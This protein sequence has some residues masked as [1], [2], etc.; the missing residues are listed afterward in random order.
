MTTS[1]AA[2]L[3]DGLVLHFD[4][5]GGPVRLPDDVLHGL[6]DLTVTAQVGHLPGGRRTITCTLG[7]GTAIHYEDGVET[8]RKTSAATTPDAIDD[9]IATCAGRAADGSLQS[10]VRDFRLYR[11]VLAPGEVRE[12]GKETASARPGADLASLDLG[13]ASAVTEDLTLSTRAPG[14]SVI[15]WES[16]RPS[17]LS[18]TGVVTRPAPRAGS[19][20][21]T[22]TATASYAGYTATRDFTVTVLEDITDRQKVDDALR[23]VV[24]PD[25]IRGDL[26]LPAKGSRDV[27]FS[28]QSSDPRVVSTTGEVTRPPHGARPRVARISVRA[29]KGYTY[30]TRY[31]ALT[32]LPLPEKA[33]ME[34]T[35]FTYVTG[36]AGQDVHFAVS[37]GDPARKTELNRGRPVL[38]SEYGVRDPFIIRSED[39]DSFSLLA[40]RQDGSH[41]EIWESTDLVTWSGQRHVPVSAG[42]PRFGTALPVSKTELERLKQGPQPVRAN[43]KGVLVDYDL[44]S[45]SGPVVADL[46]GNRRAATIRGDVTRSS[47]G[48]IF[49]G[50]RGYLDL[51]DDLTSGLDQL[52]VSAQVEVEGNWHTITCTLSNGTARLFDNNVEF[53]R[54]DGVVVKP[55]ELGGLITTPDS[56]PRFQGKMRRLTVWNRVLAEPE[57]AALQR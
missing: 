52:T 24:I 19:S 22:L 11:R 46:S 9:T 26:T 33:A 50:K 13:D 34:G 35:L 55:D 39:G 32:V 49:G 7:G 53:A 17:V 4:R 41:V 27:T 48:L 51:P 16:N 18:A 8:G 28:W 42:T 20:T 54:L 5:T 44:A 3:D 47:A 23:D 40:M 12:L 31:F 1:S 56:G 37:G 43:E 25:E 10:E 2:T 29:A 14:G 21:V 15:S 57:I 30:N 38:T 36:D 45:G 6:T